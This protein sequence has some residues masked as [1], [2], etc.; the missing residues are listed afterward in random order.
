M[1]SKNVNSIDIC[2]FIMSICVVA[3]HI[4]PLANCNNDLLLSVYNNIVSLAVPFFLLQQDIFYFIEWGI[5]YLVR[6]L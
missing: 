6:K 1:M 2:K 3:I 4:H 5:I